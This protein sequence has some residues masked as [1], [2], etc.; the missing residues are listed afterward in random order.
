MGTGALNCAMPDVNAAIRVSDI[1]AVSRAAI[2]ALRLRNEQLNSIAVKD[3]DWSDLI[4]VTTTGLFGIRSAHG[5]ATFT[6]NLGHLV[7]N[8]AFLQFNGTT[9]AGVYPRDPSL[10]MNHTKVKACWLAYAKA[11]ATEHA[12]GG[13]PAG[14]E[15]SGHAGARIVFMYVSDIVLYTPDHYVTWS[16]V[17]EDNGNPLRTM[18]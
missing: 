6:F 16:L 7:A 17:C 4:P 11:A 1:D 8:P 5:A 15:F 14:I 3:F 9:W 13:I 2:A 12:G 10:G 18:P